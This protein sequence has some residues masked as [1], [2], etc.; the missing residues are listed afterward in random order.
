MGVSN[1]N[2]EEVLK[3]DPKTVCGLKI[4]MG[5]S[6][7]NMLVDNE[8]TLEKVFSSTKLLIA[9]HCEDEQTIKHNLNLFQQKYGNQLNASHHPLIRSEEAC[10]IS[11]HKAVELAKKY[12]TRL[13][14]LHISTAKELS[15]F[16]NEK[17]L[18]DKHI[19]SEA[20][21]HHL[22]FS[23]QDYV[24]K[25]NWIKWNPA[26]KTQYDQQKLWEAI[27]N[28]IIDVIATD[29]APHTIE[30]KN[31]PYLDAPS[32]G[33]LVQHALSAMIDQYQDGKVS[34][35]KIVE[36]MC[37][38]PAICFQLKKRGFI[39]KG[40]KADLV[41]FSLTQSQTVTS[42]NILYKSG[43]SPFLNKTFKN[44]ITHTLLNGNLVYKHG[45]FSENTKGERLE[46]ER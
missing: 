17:E 29:H 38:H 25:G 24:K 27:E 11:S 44:T 41:L 39:R 22:C 7:G 6:T 34:L 33:P 42:E 26:I 14:V 1:D 20:C 45:R 8:K 23:D 12:E 9:T 15:L 46:F 21:V 10:Y 36:K 16:S 30:E 40:Y 32:G 19:T 31:K 4:F 28:N 43:W 5:S 18:K 37:H 2:Y 3:T 35:E 13:H